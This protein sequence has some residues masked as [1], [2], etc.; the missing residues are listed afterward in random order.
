MDALHVASHNVREDIQGKLSNILLINISERIFFILLVL[1]PIVFFPV[2]VVPVGVVPVGFSLIGLIFIL[3][4]F[5]PVCPI[6]YFEIF[7]IF[8]A[9]A[10]FATNLGDWSV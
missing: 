3:V 5:F 10:T 6:Y 8:A 4:F 1:L 9:C 7:I 2:D